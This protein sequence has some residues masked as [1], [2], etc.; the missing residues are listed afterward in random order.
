M[1]D[2]RLQLSLLSFYEKGLL[3]DIT[4]IAQGREIKA[5][6]AVLAAQSEW[7]LNQFHAAPN[8][9]TIEVPY[10][11]KV[12]RALV[13]FMYFGG[14][15][16]STDLGPEEGLDMV[17][18]SED[19]GITALDGADCEPLIVPRLTMQ[20][21]INVLL[22]EGLG[23][24]AAL[25]Q[26]V[27]DF[28]GTHFLKMLGTMEEELNSIPR[29]LLAPVLKMACKLVSSD[30]DTEKI[31]RFCLGHTQLETACDLLRETKQWNWG[32][33][34]ASEMRS[35]PKEVISS[36]PEWQIENVRSAMADTP[37]RI[38]TGN[39]F[40]WCI[41][42]DYGTEGKLRIVY[43]SATPR[44]AEDGSGAVP[45]RC[46]NR[47]PAAMFAW[48]VL[49]R[50]QDVFNEK[51]VFICFPENVQLHWSTTLPVSAT[52]LSDDDD[53]RIMVN[54]AENPMLSLVLYYFSADLKATVMSEDILNRLPHIEYRCLSSY[55]IVRNHL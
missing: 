48:R 44:G 31:V 2:Q 20:N 34:E 12:M 35:P 51:P 17:L 53:L 54:M 6:K 16:A 36:G 24:H 7:F 15:A 43:E 47:F 38:V 49:Y 11:Y 26:S 41:R 21:S 45:N 14:V 25:Q 9:P 37:A 33:D 23:R 46:I 19:L 10:K 28:V 4:I 13:R 30:A 52:E 42:L 29:H 3:T 50:G 18:L 27:C 32:G 1:S 8:K 39:F 40:D 22:H 55:S 5:H